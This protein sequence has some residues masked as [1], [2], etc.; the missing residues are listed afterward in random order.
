VEWTVFCGCKINY[1]VRKISPTNTGSNQLP[2]ASVVFAGSP[3]IVAT[4]R[5]QSMPCWART[6]LLNWS[7]S[8]ARSVESAEIE[9]LPFS[10]PVT[11][12]KSCFRGPAWYLRSM[13]QIKPSTCIISEL[14]NVLGFFGL[15]YKN[16]TDQPSTA[17]GR[18]R[19]YIDRFPPTAIACHR[20]CHRL[21]TCQSVREMFLVG[22]NSISNKRW[23]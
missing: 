5:S 6:E 10:C 19:G 15:A 20:W 13:T 17:R 4:K 23:R 2:R 18:G 1:L 16:D 7:V 14:I 3:E 12:G 11:H 9:L 22:D 21:L 8:C